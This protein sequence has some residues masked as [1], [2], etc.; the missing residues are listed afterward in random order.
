MREAGSHAGA[1]KEERKTRRHPFRKQREK[2]LYSLILSH[3]RSF[4]NKRS[5]PNQSEN[6]RR[7]SILDNNERASIYLRASRLL[8]NMPT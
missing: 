5:P 7:P 6:P 3:Q 4:W 1:E 2:D 8:D